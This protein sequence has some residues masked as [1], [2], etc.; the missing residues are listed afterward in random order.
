MMQ[1]S[2][3]H[4]RA[5]FISGSFFSINLTTSILF[6]PPLRTQTKAKGEIALLDNNMKSRKQQFGIEMYDLME[7]KKTFGGKSETEPKVVEVFD[8]AAKDIAMIIEKKDAKQGEIDALGAN[9]KDL[10]AESMGEKAKKA[11][12]QAKDAAVKAKTQAEMALLDREIKGRK[13]LFGIQLF[14]AIMQMEGYEPSDSEV[15]AILDG[16]KADIGEHQAKKDVKLEEINVLEA[17]QS[18]SQAAPAE[19]NATV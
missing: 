15:K 6:P 10:P 17:E 14:D 2:Q 11:G 4:T 5:M 3:A 19:S 18:A 16:A 9:D 13:Q 7:Q 12:N 1:Y 8:Q